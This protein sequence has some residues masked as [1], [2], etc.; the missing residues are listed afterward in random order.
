MIALE[1]PFVQLTEGGEEDTNKHGD[2][3]GE[4][5]LG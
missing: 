3:N 1:W 5:L 2:E 4:Q